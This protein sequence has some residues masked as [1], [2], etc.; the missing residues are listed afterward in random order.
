MEK[1]LNEAKKELH[2]MGEQGLSTNNLEA[3]AKLASLVKNIEKI[4]K[5]EKECEEEGHMRDYGYRGE[6]RERGNYRD[7]YGRYDEDYGRRSR[8]S[9]G[10]YRGDDRFHEHLDR[11]MD[12]AEEYEYSRSRYR[13]GNEERIYD[14]LEKLMYALCMF[15]ESTMDFAESPEEKEIIRKHIRK[16]REI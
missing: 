8:D 1:L 16:I 14:G 15:V 13:G 2:E 10:R 6:Y 9:M 5:M 11:L 3:V 12:G 7:D 4:N